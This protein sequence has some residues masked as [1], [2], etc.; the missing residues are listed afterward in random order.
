MIFQRARVLPGRVRKFLVLTV[1]LSGMA[2]AQSDTLAKPAA[3]AKSAVSH[4]ASPAKP[5][6]HVTPEPIK[7]SPAPT[8]TVPAKTE[9]VQPSAVKQPVPP[10]TDTVP[11]PLRN[12]GQKALKV[13]EKLVF[14][15]IWG[16]WSFRWVRAG[17]STLELLPTDRPEVWK[18][19]S[20]AWCTGFF[21]SFYPV[22]DTVSS[23]IDSRGVYP[24]QF[25]KHLNEGSYHAD[26]SAR[27]DQVAHTLKTQDTTFSIEPFTHDVLSAFYFIRTQ[28]IEVGDTL[29][30]AAVS[31][32]KK[33]NLKVLCH[34]RETITVP[35]GTF[36]TLV[37]E[38]VLKD[39]GLFKA[40]GKLTIWVTDDA[41]HT[42]VKMQSK[43]P[44]GSIKAELVSKS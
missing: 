35:A 44:V 20:L 10:K 26:I 21:Q 22:Q 14:D 30:L 4:A 43:I 41:A 16:G 3:K 29:D 33:Y 38:P 19:R 11:P 25:D 28:K 40:K 36:E 17:R 9:A 42:P 15:I 8:A 7:K 13:P 39:D 2:N 12:L 24:L 5:K 34:G 37:V 23:L 1:A 31:G 27:Y 18:I 32:K 6:T